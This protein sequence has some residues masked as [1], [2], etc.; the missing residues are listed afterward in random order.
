[1][2]GVGKRRGAQPGIPRQYDAH[3][4][5]GNAG[6][7]GLAVAVLTAFGERDAAL[8]NAE[9]GPRRHLQTMPT[10]GLVSTRGGRQVRQ[11]RYRTS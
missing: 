8:R 9:G 1:M 4:P 3:A 2:V 6:L 5:T 10:M 7:E 11:R